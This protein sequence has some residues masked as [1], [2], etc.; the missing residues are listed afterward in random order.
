MS[1]ELPHYSLPFRFEQLRSG[2]QVIPVNEQDT[3]EDIGDCVELTLRYEQGQ[4]RGRPSFGRPQMLTF[5]T[6]RDLARAMVQQAI[7]DA[8]P[9][10]RA[11]VEGGRIDPSDPGMLRIYAMWNVDLEGDS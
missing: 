6:D 2:E 7:T 4:H 1:A 8:E 3:L 10:V 5:T 11:L 9:R